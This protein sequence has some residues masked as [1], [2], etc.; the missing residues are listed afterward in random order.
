MPWSEYFG[1][2]IERRSSSDAHSGANNGKLADPCLIANLDVR[3]ED[4]I[5]DDCPRADTATVEHSRGF[6]LGAGGDLNA[7]AQSRTWANRRAGGNA[8]VVAE[9]RWSDQ[10]AFD[11][12]SLSD[13]QPSVVKSRPGFG[14]NCAAENVGG[15][16]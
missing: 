14:F 13:R 5:A 9:N 7:V 11:S 10:F 15:R 16:F 12:A 2:V 8:A 6:D 4:R 3:R 1:A